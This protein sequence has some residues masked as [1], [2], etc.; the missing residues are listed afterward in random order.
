MTETTEKT[1][2]VSVS[3]LTDELRLGSITLIEYLRDLAPVHTVKMGKGVAKF[4]DRAA[5]EAMIRKR[6]EQ[7]AKRT[8]APDAPVREPDQSAMLARLAGIENIV[9][10]ILGNTEQM[11]EDRAQIKKLLDQNAL[12]FKAINDL[13]GALTTARAPSN[14]TAEPAPPPPIVAPPHWDAPA[15]PPATKRALKRVAIVGLRSTHQLLIEKE[16]REC[17]ELSIY[18]SEECKGKAFEDSIGRADH[19]IA[20]QAGMND[21]FDATKRAA[22]NRLIRVTGGLSTLR[23]KLTDLFVNSAKS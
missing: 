17:F 7:S 14:S 15:A 22:G 3:Q 16:F 1:T 5:A 20:M 2:L 21:G 4:Y 8:R 9:S 13:R 12:I 6:V 11:D 10:D 23:D 18:A 19:V